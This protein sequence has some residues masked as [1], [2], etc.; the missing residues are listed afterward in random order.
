MK[1]GTNE[2]WSKFFAN[3]ALMKPPSENT[4]DVSSTARDDREQVLD[5]QVR[6]EQRD[7]RDDEPDQQAAHHAAAT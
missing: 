6:E 5:V 1:V 4:I 7:H 2:I 3:T